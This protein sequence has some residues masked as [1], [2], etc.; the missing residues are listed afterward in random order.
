M[1]GDSRLLKNSLSSG[2]LT[3][4]AQ[5]FSGDFE[6]RAFISRSTDST[7]KQKYYVQGMVN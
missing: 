4:K 1:A 3:I 2:D 7:A 5:N 6:K